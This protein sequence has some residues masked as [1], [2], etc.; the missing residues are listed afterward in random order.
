VSATIKEHPI[1]FSDAM[2][3][4]ILDGN[5]T[6]TRRVVKKETC[7]YGRQ[8]DRLWVR[9]AFARL[10]I[11]PYEIPPE[12]D[13]EPYLW[14]YRA[15][16]YPRPR[17][18]G[19]EDRWLAKKIHTTRWKPGIHM[20]RARSRITLEVTD[21]R[22]ERLQDISEAD[23]E[24]E[25][26]WYGKAAYELYEPSTGGLRTRRECFR[27][28]WNYI[29]GKSCAWASNPRVWVIEFRKLSRP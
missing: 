10:D 15:D 20:P 13:P 7:P 16:H 5:K 17:P 9:E 11:L 18:L 3:R 24:A 14:A 28:L 27:E 21:V 6:Q 23:A 26:G 8:G 12:F 2:V 25:G 1:L 4:A 19:W 22:Q 29:N